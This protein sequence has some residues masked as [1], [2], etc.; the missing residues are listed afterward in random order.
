M[1]SHVLNGVYRGPQGP[2]VL[3]QGGDSLG[4]HSGGAEM[5]SGARAPDARRLSRGA[6]RHRRLPVRSLALAGVL[7]VSAPASAAV[8][9]DRAAAR[10]PAPAAHEAHH[11]VNPRRNVGHIRAM[12]PEGETLLT[13]SCS[14]TRSCLT[15]GADET[16]I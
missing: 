4:Q 13:V 11:A 1:L 8:L 16:R 3:V 15:V 5:A 6:K 7:L 9:S 12:I 2:A 14:T 10:R